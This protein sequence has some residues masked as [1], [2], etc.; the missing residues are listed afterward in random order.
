MK[1]GKHSARVHLKK[2]N[3]AD[4]HEAGK[5][6]GTLDALEASAHVPV[7]EQVAIQP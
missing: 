3:P 4:A 1:T 2:V 5:Y 7:D 6:A